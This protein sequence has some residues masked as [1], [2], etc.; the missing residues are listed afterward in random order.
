MLLK[1]VI[2]D[3]NWFKLTEIFWER[4]FCSVKEGW[5]R[6]TSRTALS[7]QLCEQNFKTCSWTGCRGEW[8][9]ASSLSIGGR[10]CVWTST[11]ATR[12][13]ATSRA[14]PCCPRA[15]PTQWCGWR[16]L[17]FKLCFS[18]GKCRPWGLL[19]LSARVRHQQHR[20]KQQAKLRVDFACLEVVA[21]LHLSFYTRSGMVLVRLLRLLP[22]CSPSCWAARASSPARDPRGEGIRATAWPRKQQLP[23]QEISEPDLTQQMLGA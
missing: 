14:P 16:I 10:G 5:N 21:S 6:T 13:W 1:T 22:A 3:S 7:H 2:T 12:A 20:R 19:V 18:S 4:Y 15:L 9:E 11:R 8:A 17:C 23:F